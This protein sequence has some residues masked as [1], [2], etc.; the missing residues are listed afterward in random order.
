MAL[1]LLALAVVAAVALIVTGS[2]E[3]ELVARDLSNKERF[4]AFEH[5]KAAGINETPKPVSAAIAAEVAS[6]QAEAQVDAK[7]DAK[8]V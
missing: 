1:A 7:W 4:A 5:L 3:T 2:D 6:A 8:S